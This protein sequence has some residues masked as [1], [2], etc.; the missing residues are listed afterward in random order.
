[1]EGG[2]RRELVVFVDGS[3]CCRDASSARKVAIAVKRVFARSKV[4]QQAVSAEDGSR[5]RIW[6]R[7]RKAGAIAHAGQHHCFSYERGLP[8]GP[9]EGLGNVAGWAQST[10]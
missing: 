1:M 5:S 7:Q 6:A 8:H 10:W 9:F 4:A 2:L 3:E